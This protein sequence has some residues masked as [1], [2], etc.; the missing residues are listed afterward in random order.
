M[1]YVDV[2]KDLTNIKTKFIGNF[3]NSFVLP[4]CL[5]PYLSSVF[6]CG[7]CWI[8]NNVCLAVIEKSGGS[9]KRQYIPLLWR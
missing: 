2:P 6:S 1:A 3:T 5:V 8:P 7:S 9:R 4:E